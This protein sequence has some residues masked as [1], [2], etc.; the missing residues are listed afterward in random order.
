[1]NY[2]DVCFWLYAVVL[3]IL[4]VIFLM[5]FIRIRNEV[6]KEIDSQNHKE[7]PDCIMPEIPYC[8]CCRYGLVE[9]I[10]DSSIYG[11]AALT[12]WICLLDHPESR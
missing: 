1:M 11:D 5:P 3:C 8:P 6:W 12:K 9:E 2:I 7:H 10:E 4:C